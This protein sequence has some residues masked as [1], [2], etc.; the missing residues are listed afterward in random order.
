M[1]TTYNNCQMGIV[2]TS[3]N[4]SVIYPQTKASLVSCD[5]AKYGGSSNV[6]NVQSV[7]NNLSTALGNYLPLSRTTVSVSCTNKMSTVVG[8][9]TYY[10]TGSISSAYRIVSILPMSPGDNT[11]WM[12]V[13]KLTY[14]SVNTFIIQANGSAPIS[15]DI[16]Y[17]TA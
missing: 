4:L 12:I 6:T 2:D 8:P 7:L 13:P 17:T 14:N 11:I 10:G 9:F 1:A 3:G 5:S 16:L 15:V